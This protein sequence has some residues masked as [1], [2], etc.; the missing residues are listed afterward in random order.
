MRRST[1]R[2]AALG[3]ALTLI[4]VCSAC[5]WIQFMGNAALN[6]VPQ[7][8]STV[9]ASNV[10]QLAQTYTIALPGSVG[11]S[12]VLS[13]GRGFVSTGD[14]RLVAASAGTT[15]CT[16]SPLVCQ[17]LWTASYPG[18]DTVGTPLV[19]N[20]VVYETYADSKGTVAALAAYDANGVTNCAG[21][22][23]V[24]EP[25]W[26]APVATLTGV[27]ID[28][29]RLL[30][31]NLE[32]G[33]LEAYDPAGVTDCSG[34]PKVCQPL[35][36]APDTSIFWPSIADGQVYLANFT[37]P[38][39][40]VSVYDETGSTNCTGSPVV[41]QPLWTVALPGEGMGGVDVSGGV[42]YVQA[43]PSAG[44]FPTL[45]AFDATGTTNCTGTPKV[46]Q[47]LWTAPLSS[48]TYLTDTPAVANGLVYAGSG[49][50]QVFDAAGV[51]GCSGT[52]TVCQPIRGDTGQAGDQTV[53]NGLLFAG[54]NIYAATGSNDCTTAVP[55]ICSPLW[56]APGL[57]NQY[58]YS[59]LV[60]G[61]VFIS[62]H[63]DFI[64]AYRVPGT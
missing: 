23:L 43:R 44:G 55:S 16:G 25:L 40:T 15:G 30:V 17:P 9:N 46:C 14:G 1:N 64:H 54:V 27:N 33:S 4:L 41:C 8:E 38:T 39:G 28:Q 56:T 32:T 61:T 35:W 3:V 31:A 53:A 26:T 36:S 5:D 11:R 49:G 62:G 37:G 45:V 29:G 48:P 6:G 59:I 24:C 60:N 2:L 21:T 42:G 13:Q 57:A 58:A 63:D 10:A 51:T 12:L 47:P 20:N 22:P 7:Y 52:P 19:A 50:D 34:T 18:A